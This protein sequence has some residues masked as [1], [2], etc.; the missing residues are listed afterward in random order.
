MQKSVLIETY[1]NVK[2]MEWTE[3]W[4]MHFVLIE[5]YWNVKVEE[6]CNEEFERRVLIET[7]W[8]VKYHRIIVR[9]NT[10]MY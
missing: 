7:Y 6:W 8:N 2:M 5:T 3:K 1:W 4:L 10:D 9:G